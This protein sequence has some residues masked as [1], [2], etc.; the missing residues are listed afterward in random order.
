[1]TVSM[2]LWSLDTTGA[3]TR[4]STWGSE[5]KYRASAAAFCRSAAVIPLS[6][7]YTTRAGL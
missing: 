1:M 6:R 4:P 2:A 7:T 5:A 3:A